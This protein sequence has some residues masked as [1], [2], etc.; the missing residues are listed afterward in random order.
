MTRPYQPGQM[1]SQQ[2]PSFV[3]NINRNKTRKWTEARQNNYDGDDWGDS[4]DIYDD[5]AQSAPDAQP[6]PSATH[7]PDFRSQPSR[8]PPPPS[9]GTPSHGTPS[10]RDFSQPTQVP[11]ALGTSSDQSAHPPPTSS[12]NR[13]QPVVASPEMDK[14]LPPAHIVR[15]ADIYKRMAAE[16]EKERLSSHS[17]QPADSKPLPVNPTARDLPISSSDDHSAHSSTPSQSEILSTGLGLSEKPEVEQD[18]PKASKAL[19][20]SP[21]KT[22][23]PPSPTPGRVR[24]LADKF[25][26]YSSRDTSPVS[27]SKASFSSWN[28]SETSSRHSQPN[29]KTSNSPTRPQQRDDT[30]THT[31]LEAPPSF[32]PSIPG[33]W[34]S[35]TT[36]PQP[37]AASTQSTPQIP[38]KDSTPTKDTASSL[39]LLDTDSTPKARD[40]PVSDSLSSP[41]AHLT[42][43]GSA[44]GAALAATTEPLMQTFTSTSSTDGSGPATRTSPPPVVGDVLLRPLALDRAAT[45]V[46]SSVPPSPLPKDTPSVEPLQKAATHKTSG[47]FNT[48]PQV[49]PAEELSRPSTA[50]SAASDGEDSES[51]RL[52]RDIVRSLD[53]IRDTSQQTALTSL[54]AVATQPRAA[55]E[56]EHRTFALTDD[57]D[58]PA[59]STSRSASGAAPPARPAML[60]QR[61]SWEEPTAT[62]DELPD[63]LPTRNISASPSAMH[64][65]D[66]TEEKPV[67]PEGDT[68]VDKDRPQ[69]PVSPVVPAQSQSHVADDDIE[70][71]HGP[72]ADTPPL[73]DAHSPPLDV[74]KPLPTVTGFR[75]QRDASRSVSAQ[76]KIPTFR[77]LL[78]ITSTEDR[79]LAFKSAQTSTA[80][81]DSGLQ[82][83][84][85]AMISSRPEHASLATAVPQRPMDTSE[86][87]G[88]RI[89]APSLNRIANA[90]GS[91]TSSNTDGLGRS[92]SH[93]DSESMHSTQHASLLKSKELL[94]KSVVGAKGWLAK[95]K[96]KLR[97]GGSAKV[98]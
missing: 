36:S 3:A 56:P 15:P 11:P 66:E 58:T 44:L 59:P 70:D 90:L 98:D 45:S 93:K 54:D 49:V 46:A 21:T 84:I 26:D 65:V 22:A 41:L 81:T 17:S 30:S 33:Q 71:L 96:Q 37:N 38:Q 31:D 42:A 57:T 16:K 72:S 6:Q 94:G 86:L 78:A 34:V 79:I 83:W 48:T 74:S 95:G 75:S 53:P 97:E 52:R 5:Y 7:P 40:M 80:H 27:P 12:F 19:P 1:P 9:H 82:D 18:T 87:P 63:E 35:Y 88:R 32:R 77:E 91:S 4:D 8:G 47:Y 73:V 89:A 39:P 29:E 51:D 62:P 55:Q 13:Q 10:S 2:Q 61:F 64:H 85:G 50:A 60:D 67:S 43:A 23:P 20:P 25:N 92:A 76:T 68:P 14:P 28:E 69:S 24:H